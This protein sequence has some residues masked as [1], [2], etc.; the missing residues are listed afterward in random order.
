MCLNPNLNSFSSEHTCTPT[1]AHTHTHTHTLLEIQLRR[2]LSNLS[3]LISPLTHVYQRCAPGGY[4]GNQTG[5]V[6]GQGFQVLL[7]CSL[8][9]PLVALQEQTQQQ[10]RGLITRLMPEA[11][12]D[13]AAA[14]HNPPM[15]QVWGVVA[16]VA[17]VV[18]TDT[19]NAFVAPFSQGH[20]TK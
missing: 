19:S 11:A 17:F 10:E 13:A 15:C 8:R 14:V 2:I 20:V 18:M 9:F 7:L 6:G 5:S 1:H 16:R 12:S 4:L 3:S